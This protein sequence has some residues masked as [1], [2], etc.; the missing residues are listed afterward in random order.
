M[1]TE[2]DGK[3]RTLMGKPFFSV[4]VPEHN[5]VQ[6]MRK[7][8]D[9]IKQQDFTDYELIII[10]DKCEDGTAAVAREYSDKVL[11]TE[12]GLCGL[13]RNAGL[14]IA[15][16][17]YVLFMD[18][19]DRWMAGNAFRQIHDMAVAEEPDI[20]F[21]NFWWNH[22][23]FYD[24]KKNGYCWAVWNKAWR[25]DFIGEVR[26]DDFEYGEDVAWMKTMMAKNPKR[27]YLSSALYF[28]DYMRYNSQSWK[29]E[30]GLVKY[31][32]SGD[33]KVDKT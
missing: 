9:S 32:S 14:D 26:F 7:G 30:R 3:G 19:D 11:T 4:I 8:L 15:E 16:G 13:S 23:G 5:A 10:C 31:Q 1:A 29:Y 6:F 33:G 17:E 20:L 18:D 22:R 28:Y 27:S 24:Q 21:F 2:A 12:F 25:R